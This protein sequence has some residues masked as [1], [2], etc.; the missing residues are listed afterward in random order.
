MAL[1]RLQAIS[2]GKLMNDALEPATSLPPVEVVQAAQSGWRLFPCNGKKPCIK[3]WPQQATCN[4]LQLEAWAAQFVNCNWA[5]TTG[6]ESGVFV[7]DCDG[8]AGLD[9]LKAQID[10]GNELPEGWAVHTARG[11]HLYF[12]WTA[13]L[14]IR[15][16]ASKLARGVDIRGIG[17]YVIIPPSTHP[18]GPQYAAVD[19]ACPVSPAPAWLLDLIRNISDPPAPAKTVQPRWDTIPEGRRN[20]KLTSTGGYLRRKGLSQTE[21]EAA[22]LQDNQRRCNPPLPDAEVSRIAASV[23]RYPVGGPDPLETAWQAVQPL[24][25]ASGY[26]TFIRLAVSLQTAREELDVAL[27]LKRIAELFGVAFTTVAYWRKKAVARGIFKPTAQYIA[28]RKAG[29]YRVDLEAANQPIIKSKDFVTKP[30]TTV[31]TG[32]VTNPRRLTIVT[33][34]MNS[35]VIKTDDASAFDFGYNADS[36]LAH[37]RGIA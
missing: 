33:N 13:G 9:W 26:E 23:A 35:I 27:P 1:R 36:F 10:A 12:A 17:G 31:T 3:G 19:D 22:L 20:D 16:S 6:P 15:N 28:H 18:D 29:C 5:A 2:K 24:G 11:L 8:D 32:L 30:V 34:D 7:V 21:I 25:S 37:E 4:L 14:E